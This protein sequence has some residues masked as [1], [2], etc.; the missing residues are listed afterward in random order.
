[1]NKNLL[2]VAGACLGVLVLTCMPQ[3]ASG[4]WEI[5][6]VYEILEG[7]V[8]ILDVDIDL[9]GVE[10]GTSLGESDNW[11]FSMVLLYGTVDYELFGVN[12]NSVLDTDMFLVDHNISYEYGDS[13]IKPV[14]TAGVGYGLVN[15]ELAPGSGLGL[16][17]TNLDFTYNFGAGV[18]WDMT[19]SLRLKGM[20]KFR[21]II[22]D[23][24]YDIDG[25]SFSLLYKIN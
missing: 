23:F 14:A 18:I 13:A 4:S 16:A 5:G 11:R 9:Y 25:F 21:T 8:S 22:D 20:Y 12:F 3:I 15:H 24:D 17:D 19:D 7:D 2:N 1:M 10:F 6:G